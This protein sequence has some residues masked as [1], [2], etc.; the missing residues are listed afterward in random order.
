MKKFLALILTL[1]LLTT[2]VSSLADVDLAG[3]SFH[4]L[5]ALKDRINKAIWESQEWEEVT[6]P[7]GVY[8]VGKDIPAG[9]WTVRA[10]DGQWAT[11]QWGDVLTE[12]GRQLSYLGAIYE[13]ELLTSP[14]NGTYEE[15]DLTE[16]DF[17]LRDG[18]Y[19]IIDDGQM[20]FSPY[21]GKPPFGFAAFGA[22][23]SDPVEPV[24][25]VDPDDAVDTIYSQVSAQSILDA[26]QA[27][28]YI[29]TVQIEKSGYM[30]AYESNNTKSGIAFRVHH[31]ERFWCKEETADG[32]Y[33][34]AFVDGSVGYVPE[35]G[36]A[37]QRGVLDEAAF[38]AISDDNIFTIRTTG[39]AT[40]FSQPKSGGESRRESGGSTST[41]YVPSGT[42]RICFGRTYRQNRDWYVSVAINQSNVLEIMWLRAADCE[43]LKSEQDVFTIPAWWYD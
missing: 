7:A 26:Y 24:V 39:K 14:S 6:V 36:T 4:E 8:V 27:T 19:V 1:L 42:E 35:K 21:S 5:V 23:Q 31:G 13:Y 29:G 9:H 2:A 38:S 37:L 16:T 20:V 40:V 10:A 15:D 34:I 25:P 12:S 3:M 43:V 32:W 11:I 28:Q 33:A 30:N 18:L 41:F 22:G 17:L